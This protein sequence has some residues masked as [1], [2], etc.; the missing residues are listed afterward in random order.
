MAQGSDGKPD[1]TSSKIGG[2]LSSRLDRLGRELKRRSDLKTAEDA[3][4]RKPRSD[5]SGLA[6]A[7][8]V[9]SEFI[10][11]VIV[12]GVIGWGVDRLAGSSPWGMIVFLMLGFVAGVLNVMRSAGLM[13]KPKA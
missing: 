8:R 4:T 12:G 2:D 1:P 13:S 3:G 10:A 9:G 6:L 5:A 11:A 7:M